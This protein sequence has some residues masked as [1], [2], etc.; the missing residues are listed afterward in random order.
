VRGYD[1]GNS[2]VSISLVEVESFSS[3]HPITV[4][5]EVWSGAWG[6]RPVS[7]AC[8]NHILQGGL[9]FEAGSP[10]IPEAKMT[11]PSKKKSQWNPGGFRNGNSDP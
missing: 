7:Q 8:Y 2:R 10:R 3:S 4:K 11:N 6:M 5:D 9:P 1:A